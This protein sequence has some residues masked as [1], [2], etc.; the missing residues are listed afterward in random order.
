MS[1]DPDRVETLVSKFEELFTGE[2][3][4]TYE[5]FNFNERNKE[6][7]ESFDA[8]LIALTNMAE[9]CNFCSCPAMTDSLLRD[10]IVL[11]I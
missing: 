4:E 7:G 2:A 3:N 9:T 11:G 8:F 5:S 6:V 1:E 10:R